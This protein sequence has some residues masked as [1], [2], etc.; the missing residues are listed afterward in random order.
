MVSNTWVLGLWRR[1]NKSRS[2]F[3]IHL[4]KLSL[5]GRTEW[6]T[7]T[8][9]VSICSEL[10]LFNLSQQFSTY[11]K[12]SFSA[13]RANTRPGSSGGTYFSRYAWIVDSN[14]DCSDFQRYYAVLAGECSAS[15]AIRHWTGWITLFARGI[16]ED[17]R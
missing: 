4:Q 3:I 6:S 7:R 14:D 11:S 9:T 2:I 17:R 16:S 1:P 12:P 5:P 13:G 10:L 15:P 8:A